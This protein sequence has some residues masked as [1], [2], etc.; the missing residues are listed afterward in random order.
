MMELAPR[1]IVARAMDSEMKK[2][3]QNFVY[4]NLTHLSKETI[5][6]KFPFIKKT[7]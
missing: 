2:K 7:M 4:L 3:G 6:L 5:N 1:D